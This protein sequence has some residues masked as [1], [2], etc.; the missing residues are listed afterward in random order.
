M[1]CSIVEFQEL[2]LY[3]PQEWGVWRL[4]PLGYLVHDTTDYCIDVIGF[5]SVSDFV[6]WTYQLNGK[7]EE[8]YGATILSDF[9]YFTK[10]LFSASGIKDIRDADPNTTGKTLL[11]QYWK[12]HRKPRTIPLQ[13]RHSVLERDGFRCCDCGASPANGA[14]LQVDHTIPVA[15]G[16]ETHISNLRTLCQECNLGKSDRIIAY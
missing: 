6:F 1:T 9:I 10:A 11:K 12:K 4:D 14:R 2:S 7:N 5:Q 8:V 13:L 15:K 16:G 3:R